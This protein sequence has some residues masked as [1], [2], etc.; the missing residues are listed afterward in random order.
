M[1]L[2]FASL[3]PVSEAIRSIF[4]KKASRTVQPIYISWAN[5]FFPFFV[6]T[7]LLFFI[8]LKFN[9]NFFI[10]ITG[11]GLINILGVILYMRA[12]SESDV[13]KVMP[14]LSF[15]PLFLLVTSPI[16]VGEF[17]N[18]GGFIGVMLI[19]AGS[20]LLNIELRNKSMFEPFKALL[21]D[22]GTRI[23]LIL[24][25]M[26]SF[27]ANFDKISVKNS[28]IWQHI[29]FLNIIVFVGVTTIIIITGRF[30]FKYI[31]ENKKKLLPIS[32]FTVFS[33][34]F[35]MT[36][37]SLTLVAYVVSLKRMSG[38]LAGLLA[39]LFLKEEN[40]KSRILGASIMFIGVLFIIFS[41]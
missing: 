20:Y 27:S 41:N 23:M 9:Q 28:S 36:A 15:T 11:S 16:M 17:P 39:F 4:A 2:L 8:D 21:R 18:T 29:I 19:V 7:P 37:L 5:N 34:I 12:I 14:M 24:S 25:F 6:F 35:H 26:W 30:S 1:W 10:G 13:S 22:K 32:M 33:F 3:N 31:Y 38:V 40:I